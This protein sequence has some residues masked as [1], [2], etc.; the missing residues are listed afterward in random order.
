VP[1]ETD[2]SRK[3]YIRQR[4]VVHPLEQFTGLSPES[5]IFKAESLIPA[6][7]PPL[8]STSDLAAAVEVETY[9]YGALSD[10]KAELWSFDDFVKN[11]A[12]KWFGSEERRDV[13]SEVD[14]RRGIP[15]DMSHSA[16]Q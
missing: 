1:F 3:E 10:L 2:L 4:V 6:V 14:R 11:N 7:L 13:Y 15:R 12:W 16:S 5:Q 8:P 9:V